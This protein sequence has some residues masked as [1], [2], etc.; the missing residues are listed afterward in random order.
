MST[1]AVEN[2]KENKC[3]D[4]AAALAGITIAS[5]KNAPNRFHW[6]GLLTKAVFASLL[7]MA[8]VSAC[9]PARRQRPDRAEGQPDST[10]AANHAGE[11]TESRTESEDPASTEDVIEQIDNA[12]AREGENVASSAEPTLGGGSYGGGGV[13]R[14]CF[15]DSRTAAG[16]RNAITANEFPSY[17]ESH[18]ELITSVVIEDVWNQLMTASTP[19]FPAFVDNVLVPVIREANYHCADRRT[20]CIDTE[21]NDES[22]LRATSALSPAQQE[23]IVD[24]AFTRIS[25]FLDSEIRAI[26]ERNGSDD[27]ATTA[28]RRAFSL[29]DARSYIKSWRHVESYSLTMMP[30]DKDPNT[31]DDLCVEGAQIAIQVFQDHESRTTVKVAKHL[32]KKMDVLSR[33]A[34]RTHESFY[35]IIIVNH[36]EAD[37]SKVVQDWTIKLLLSLSRLPEN[38]DLLQRSENQTPVPEISGPN[39]VYDGVHRYF[40]PPVLDNGSSNEK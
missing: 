17:L 35:S 25:R 38:I 3:S 4:L 1:C 22:I 32:Y 15:A 20:N 10:A 39:G 7:V 14:I 37:N 40:Y 11:S 21:A 36:L 23:V 33:V 28:L 16:L 8:L 30:D 29:Q 27:L 31:S 26:A 2:R 12:T 19:G 34:L 6:S 9:Q 5:L 18:A 13:G 24:A